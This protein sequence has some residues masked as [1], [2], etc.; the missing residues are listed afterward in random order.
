MF[1]SQYLKM[2]AYIRL[3]LQMWLGLNQVQQSLTRHEKDLNVVQLLHKSWE[4]ESVGMRLESLEVKIN[5]ALASKRLG[6]SAIQHQDRSKVDWD[7]LYDRFESY[8]R[9][10]VDLVLERIRER[11]AGRLSQLAS[12]WE[13]PVFL[14]LGCGRAELL[15]VAKGCGYETRGVDLSRVAAQQAKE[16]GHQVVDG[17][18]LEELRRMPE[19]SAHVIGFLHVIEHCEPKYIAEVF[20]EVERVAVDD[21]VFIVETPSLFSIWAGMRQFYLDPTHVRPVHPEYILFLGREFGFV[22]GELLEFADVEHPQRPQFGGDTAL[23]KKLQ[24][25]ESWMFGHM[26]MTCWMSKTSLP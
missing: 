11:Y 26:D 8:F 7:H 3:R 1:R 24:K 16:K 12:Q 6:S 20:H 19:N 17:D 10:G 13:R 4:Q 9:G 25:M 14:D 5:Q 23:E 2:K 18:L 15:D 21:G 22:H